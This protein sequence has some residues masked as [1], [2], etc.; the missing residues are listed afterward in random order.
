MPA[1]DPPRKGGAALDLVL[2]KGE[3]ASAKSGERHACF[4]FQNK[5]NVKQTLDLLNR[6]LSCSEY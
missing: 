3:M 6:I 4:V 5:L 1:A 2:S